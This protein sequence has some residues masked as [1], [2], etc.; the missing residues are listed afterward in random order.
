MLEIEGK[1]SPLNFEDAR[2]L[3]DSSLKGQEKDGYELIHRPVGNLAFH[4]S[5]SPAQ[6]SVSQLLT[7]YI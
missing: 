1:S 6:I 3:E 5:S 7:F 2:D 4:N